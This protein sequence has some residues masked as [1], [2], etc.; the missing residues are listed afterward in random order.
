MP[1]QLIGLARTAGS[2]RIRLGGIGPHIGAALLLGHGHADGDPGLVGHADVA[3]VVFGGE[4]FR[5]PLLRQVRLQAHG[6]NAG[7]GHGQRTATAGFG[8]AV[9]IRH[10]SA[11]HMSAVLRVRPGQRGQAVL[12]C[13]A[14]QL[15]IGR[16]KFHQIDAMTKAVMTVEHRLVL[17]GKEPGFHQRTT[18]Q[19]PVSVDPRFGP[20]GP[21]PPRPFL[22]RQV[23]AVEVGAVQGR[24]LVGD[25][26][27]FGKLMQVHDWA[28][29]VGQGTSVKHRPSTEQS[30][31]SA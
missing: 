22:Q 15:V 9:Q 3:R 11:G 23:D 18:G 21:E 25:F 17:I 26:V 13:R 27:G 30:V 31:I 1:H 12:D 28:P 14:H 16:M 24:W 10:A 8:L 20:T 6:R 29:L 7:E 4:D 2:D 5:Q 19:R